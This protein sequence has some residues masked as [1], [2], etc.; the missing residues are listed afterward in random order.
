MSAD[1]RPA[2]GNLESEI[3]LGHYSP[4]TLESYRYESLGG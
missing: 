4:E 1:W 3:T 2:Y